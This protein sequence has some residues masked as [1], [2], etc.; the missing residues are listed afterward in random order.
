M[1]NRPFLALWGLRLNHEPSA[2]ASEGFEAGFARG[3]KRGDFGTSVAE[4]GFFSDETMLSAQP[5]TSSEVT[6]R[7]RDRVPSKIYTAVP[8]DEFLLLKDR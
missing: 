1:G 4:D 5:K 6:S 7:K 8:A 2:R 3:A